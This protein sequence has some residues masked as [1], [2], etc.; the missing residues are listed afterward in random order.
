MTHFPHDFLLH[1]TVSNFYYVASKSGLW[2]K[3]CAVLVE[4]VCVD[5]GRTATPSNGIIASQSVKT[6]G[7]AVE[8]G[9]DGGK[10]RKDASG[11]S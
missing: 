4:K 1:T 11:I 3:L 9:I 5:T 6:T 2:E 7:A 10:K 8:R